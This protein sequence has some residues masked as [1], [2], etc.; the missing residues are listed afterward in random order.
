M[1]K[2]LEINSVTWPSFFIGIIKVVIC[3]AFYVAG[4]LSGTQLSDLTIS[5][6]RERITS[7]E[8]ETAQQQVQ[9]DELKKLA[10]QNSKN[11]IALESIKNEI[12]ELR[13]KIN[14]LQG[15]HK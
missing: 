10:T 8:L 4:V 9:I 12:K 15:M 3:G 7:L 2:R 1:N 5:S 14:K 11:L 13:E 6:Q